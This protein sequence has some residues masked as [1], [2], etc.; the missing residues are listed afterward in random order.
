[1]LVPITSRRPVCVMGCDRL[2]DSTPSPSSI[3]T[4]SWLLCPLCRLYPVHAARLSP[5][6]IFLPSV[7]AQMSAICHA[8]R[9]LTPVL[10]Y[11]VPYILRSHRF[12]DNKTYIRD[13]RRPVVTLQHLNTPRR[14][15]HHYYCGIGRPIAIRWSIKHTVPSLPMSRRGL[16]NV[17]RCNV[18]T[19]ETDLIISYY[20]HR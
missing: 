12:A 17:V 13:I 3:G 14:N 7:H 4:V 15:D 2:T 8:A 1:M 10:C 9:L 6:V 18:W 5:V 11:C 19:R 16:W 20:H